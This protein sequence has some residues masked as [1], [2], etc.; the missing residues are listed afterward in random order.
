MSLNKILK[1]ENKK[2][3]LTLKV[4]PKHEWPQSQPKNLINVL[5]SRCFLVQIY[6]EK[7]AA[8]LSVCRTEVQ[9]NRWKDNIT[10]DE[11]QEL[12]R[13]CGYG[14]M[15]AV[16]IYPPDYDVVNAANMRH[17][18]VLNESPEYMWNKK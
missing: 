10:W 11:L 7:N 4:V 2:W 12:K 14:G 5:R 15:C 3:P 16:E 17:L 18:W 1:Q 8:R 9:G 13:Q 6:D